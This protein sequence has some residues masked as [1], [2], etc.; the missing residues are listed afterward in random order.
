MNTSLS[1]CLSLLLAAGG[2]QT[3]AADGIDAGKYLGASAEQPY[4]VS[5]LLRNPTGTQDFGW[6]RNAS[7]A[8]AGYNKHNA[9]FDSPDYAGVGIESWYWSPVTNADLIWQTVDGMLPGTYVVSAYVC[10]QVYNDGARKGQYGGGLALMANGARA[11]VTSG[12]WQRLSVECTLRAGESLKI[13][14]TAGADNANDWVGIAGVT[15]AC[16]GAGE[17]EKIALSEDFDLTCVRACS[18][19]DV[20]LKRSVPADGYTTLCLPFDVGPEAVAAYFAEVGEVASVARHGN[21]YVVTTAP[22]TAMERGKTY[23]VRAK[24]GAR[25]TYEFSGVLV[26]MAA[27][28]A[29]RVGGVVVRG[30]FRQQ[31]G[32]AGVHALQADGAT[33]SH[34]AGAASV[35]AYGGW[36]AGE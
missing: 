14:V 21:D 5:F 33:F 3:A 13:G 34:A 18:Y 11:A 30:S 22:A 31:D 7:D 20:V 36:V 10:G 17:P 12:K 4:D 23:V 6:S 24:D 25:S 29:H 32:V 1:I 16:V 19:A 8:A 35:K 15:V 27:Q 28:R 26:D 2:C 9:E